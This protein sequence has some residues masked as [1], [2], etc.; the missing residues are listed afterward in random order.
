MAKLGLHQRLM[1]AGFQKAR[2]RGMDGECWGNL[3][4]GIRVCFM[5]WPVRQERFWV[6][7]DFPADYARGFGSES[8]ACEHAL[9]RAE[10]SA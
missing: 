7:I 10:R 3:S 2:Y 8:A 4:K 5:E 1:R 9:E 6:C